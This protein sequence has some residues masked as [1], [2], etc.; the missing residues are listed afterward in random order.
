MTRTR[1]SRLSRWLAVAPALAIVAGLALVPHTAGRAAAASVTISFL[2]KW[3]EPQYAPYFQKVVSDYEKA[4]PNVTI[5]LQAVGDQPY[6]DK[7]RVLTAAGALPDIYFSWA[8]DFAK[9][10]VR[11]GLA[12]DLTNAFYKSSWHTT[13]GSGPAQAFTYNG[14]LYGIPIDLD[15]KFFVYNTAI[16]KQY[17]LSPP[18][19]LANLLSIC[20]TLKSHGIQPIAF[21]NQYGWPAIHYLTTL[22]SVYIPQSTLLR[23]YA[24]ETGQFTNPGYVQAL[25]TFKTI[26]QQCLTPQAN[27]I[28]HEAAQAQVLAGRAAMQYV[29]SVEFPV[30]TKAGGAPST[31]Y[32]N[33]SFFKFPYVPGAKGNQGYLTG[34]PDGFMVSPRTKHMDVVIDF[35]KFF[36]SRANGQLMTKML[37]WASPVIDS[38]TASNSFPQLRQAIDQ[39]NHA[40]GM[41]IWLDTVTNALVAQAYLAGTEGLVDGSRTPQQVM[42]SV[43]A[44]A[45]AAKKS[46][47]G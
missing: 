27:G 13:M 7:I 34:A 37:G 15:A 42:S 6:K 40:A 8:G 29:E 5:N 18:K 46:V 28:S 35:L 24:P 2:E 32:N 39:I 25:N 14:K 38:A 4:H 44:A 11:G 31:I 16:F 20:S 36:T 12:A 26:D 45:K 3:P 22:N 9:K 43:Q 41:N 47:R 30:F 23:D 17:H 10:F 1:P 33:W 21:G 19:T